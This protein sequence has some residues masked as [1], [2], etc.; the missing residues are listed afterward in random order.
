MERRLRWRRFL[1]FYGVGGD[2]MSEGGGGVVFSPA[3]AT[4][5]PH[6]RQPR[7]RHQ[8]AVAAEVDGGAV[9]R[10]LTD[11]SSQPELLLMLTWSQWP[12]ATQRSYSDK[13]SVAVAGCDGSGLA[14]NPTLTALAQEGVALEC[15]GRG[16]EVVW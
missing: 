4:I 8:V 14:L 1:F 15:G 7:R 3:M 9:R 2:E 6:L 16:G 12:P 13:K 10:Q 5:T 11:I